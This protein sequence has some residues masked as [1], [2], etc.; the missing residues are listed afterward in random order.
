MVSDPIAPN[1]PRNL[2]ARTFGEAAINLTDSGILP[3]GGTTC[4][5][6]GSAY[7]KSRSSDSFT[8]A[9]KDFIAPI[10]VNI[11]NCGSI[12]IDKVTNP[13]GSTQSFAFTLTGGPSNLNQSFN[14]TDAATPHNSG[15]VLAGSGYNAAETV[16]TG[17]D[18]TSATCSDGSPV[19]NIDV[20]VGETV[21]CTFNNR[22]DGKILV[23]K[24]TT[25]SGST[26]SFE[27]DPSY[28][29]NFNLTD[30]AAAN[31]SGLLDPGTYSVAEVNIPADWD[32]TSATCS[33]GSDP[34][35][36]ALAAGE[37]VTCTFRNRQDGKILVDKVTTPSGS[38][39]SFEFDPSY[40]GT[41]FN[42]TDAAANNDSGNLDPGTYSVAEVNIPPDWDLTS[43]SCSD[44]STVASISLQAGETITCTFN[45]R[46]DGKILVDKVTTPSGSTQSFEFD[47]SYGPNFNLTD[48]AAANDS[49]NLD[50][51][52][53]SVAEVNI[54]ADWD[55]TSSSC[56]DGS[57]VN[58]IS[59]QAG[60]TITCTF[61]NRQD[62][63]ILVDKVTDPSGSSQSFEFDPSYGP[64]FNLTDAAAA[65]DSGFLNPGT[66]SVAEVNIPT[67]WDLTS[68][69]CSD[70][71][72]VASISLQA[73]ETVTCTFNDRGRGSISIHKEDDVD[74][75]LEGAVFTLY[76]DVAPIGGTR[77]VED[78]S[79]GS[80]CT[81]GASGNCSFTNLVPGE[82]WVVETTGVPG[83]EL[84][85]DQHATVAAGETV[86]L[87]FVDPRQHLMI[88][89][90]CHMGTNTLA[91]S[92]ITLVVGEPGGGDD[93][94]LTLLGTAPAGFTQADLCGLGG[95]R[96]I[97]LNHATRTLLAVIA[98]H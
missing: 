37:T 4:A 9:I 98:T 46:Q 12:V 97:G 72:T 41:N 83:H 67:G 38:T 36:I 44:G 42:L 69:S 27:F 53:Y 24:I 54:P 22:Q 80:T 74:N 95:A 79:T 88:V 94:T 45:N 65:N 81:T 57:A 77:G 3:G 19:A 55:L 8:A 60:E 26:Q 87:T 93:I 91:P 21:T 47:P 78:T 56:S 58:A 84:A 39:Q 30:A 85:A 33:D 25:P 2:S 73:G 86:P 16:P 40:S 28:G 49:G 62:G 71:S 70:G 76:N 75:A 1:A 29:P 32:L 48:A 63:K 92:D 64:N 96:F 11:T 90:V 7:L 5:G 14:L 6:F 50:P 13:S 61:N 35:T 52:T 68:S 31:D 18:L 82:Y 23:D 15:G 34:A 66:Y 89:I 59:L 43:S 51:G 10:P 17:W 20:S